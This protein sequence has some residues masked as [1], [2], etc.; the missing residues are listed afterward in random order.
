MRL[1]YLRICYLLVPM[2]SQ[3]LTTRILTHR[4]RTADGAFSVSTPRFTFASSIPQNNLG[5]ATLLVYCRGHAAEKCS[6]KGYGSAYQQQW[7]EKGTIIGP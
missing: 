1:T 3:L 2:L 7:N 4:K 6:A 5:L